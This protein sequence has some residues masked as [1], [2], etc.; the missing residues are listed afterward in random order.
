MANS[1]NPNHTH[2][3]IPLLIIVRTQLDRMCVCML[4]HDN[5][6]FTTD[7]LKPVSARQRP[8]EQGETQEDI[9]SKNYRGRICL[10]QV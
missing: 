4:E 1:L 7:Q 2:V 9:V 8:G 3:Q 6:F 10:A 5:F